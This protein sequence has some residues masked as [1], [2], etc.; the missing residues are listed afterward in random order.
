MEVRQKALAE[1]QAEL[2]KT[3]E[4]LRA[5]VAACE[6]AQASGDAAALAAA[7]EHATKLSA[8]VKPY[9]G[10][11]VSPLVEIVTKKDTIEK[12]KALI[13]VRAR[14]CVCMYHCPCVPLYV[15]VPCS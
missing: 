6:A 10:P 7:Y 3:V 15:P 9:T 14:V 11:C 5:A 1:Q 2:T 8:S 4:Q 13:K 12:I